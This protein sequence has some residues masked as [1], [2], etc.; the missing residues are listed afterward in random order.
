MLADSSWLRP[1]PSIAALLV[2]LAAASACAQ[3]DDGTSEETSDRA[4]QPEAAPAA[5]PVLASQPGSV[6]QRLAQAEI[7]VH[8]SRPV[9]RG[10]VLFGNLVDWDEIWAPG[11]D[12]ATYLTTTAD[13]EVA[14]Q[15]LPAGSYSIWARPGRDTWTFYFH[16]EW[17]VFHLP[18]PGEEGVI[19]EVTA[20]PVTATHMETL[21][22]Y[23]PVA[24]RRDGVLA[25]HW[26]E[27][28]VDIP[29]HVPEPGD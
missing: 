9:A 25:F 29:L 27:T 14:G 19:L 2:T 20:E 10:R 13:I 24:D 1:R 11:A 12:H 21:S 17:D 8:Y 16:R 26:G 18:F 22:F 4:S 28:R 23:F 15:P 5:G 6:T 7:S 3:P